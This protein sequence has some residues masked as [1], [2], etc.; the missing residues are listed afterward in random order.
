ML[1]PLSQL[2]ANRSTFD[3]EVGALD[4]PIIKDVNQLAASKAT[5]SRLAHR[6]TQVQVPDAYK[7][8]LSAAYAVAVTILGALETEPSDGLGVSLGRGM[9]AFSTVGRKMPP[10]GAALIADAATLKPYE[11]NLQ[12]TLDAANTLRDLVNIT[13]VPTGAAPAAPERELLAT[14]TNL[15]CDVRQML[16]RYRSLDSALSGFAPAIAAMI[17]GLAS[18][19]VEAFEALGTT[20]DSLKARAGFLISADIG[21]LYAWRVNQAVPSAG[22]NV[23]FRPVNKDAHLHLDCWDG[24]CFWQRFSVTMGIA[25]ASVKRDSTIENLFGSTSAFAG[26][27][28]RIVDFARLSGGLLVFRTFHN[29]RLRHSLINTAP[30]VGASI[31]FTLK[32]LIGTVANVFK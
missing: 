31:D 14:L 16:I 3:K 18:R 23:Y 8:Q 9:A 17:A 12:L 29:D 30:Y 25:L 4:D 28:L 2:A 20:D 1:Q 32:D 7:P 27:G 11:D 6:A 15:Q 5:I 24:K 19:D 26:G 10:I 13:T 22:V 21:I